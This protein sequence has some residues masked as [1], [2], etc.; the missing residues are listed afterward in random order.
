M[1]LEEIRGNFIPLRL[2]TF[3]HLPENALILK[4]LGRVFQ[5][6]K[7]LT[8]ENLCPLPRNPESQ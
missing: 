2:K 5:V 6:E 8:T 3:H 4:I 7:N 1:L